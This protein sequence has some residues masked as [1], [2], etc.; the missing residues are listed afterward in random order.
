MSVHRSAIESR[1]PA[2]SGA[3]EFLR[4]HSNIKGSV[5]RGIAVISLVG[6]NRISATKHYVN[7]SIATLSG[8]HAIELTDFLPRL[9]RVKLSFFALTSQTVTNPPLLP[10]TMI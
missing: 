6:Y 2:F 7:T 9:F 1:A 4:S 3:L 5:S 8:S 10:V